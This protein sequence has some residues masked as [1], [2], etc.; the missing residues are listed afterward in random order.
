VDLEEKYAIAL[1]ILSILLWGGGWLLGKRIADAPPR[2][3]RVVLPI[4]AMLTMACFAVFVAVA[5]Y[6]TRG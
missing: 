3:I 5:R 2:V 4:A 1:G 6:N